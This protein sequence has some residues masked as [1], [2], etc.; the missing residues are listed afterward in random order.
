MDTGPG[1]RERKKQQ[2]RAALSLAALRLAV[3]RGL[4]NVLV[5]DIAALAGV[6]PRTFNNYFANKAEAIVW[7]HI[8]RANQTADLLRQRPTS[9]PL[10]ESITHAVVS[11]FGGESVTTSP[12]WAAGVR[13]MLSEPGLQAEFLKAVMSAERATALAIAER[14]GTDV[15]RDMYPRL[16]AAAIGAAINVATEQFLDRHTALGAFIRE[17][18]DQLRAGLPDP[19]AG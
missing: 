12:E 5:E 9:E 16:V 6:S 2:T 17:A 1:L 11:Q 15:E 14:T 7:R 8:N 4:D 3:E 18:L 13:L 10:W 19:K